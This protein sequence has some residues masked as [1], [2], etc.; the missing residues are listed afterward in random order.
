MKELLS[1]RKPVGHTEAVNSGGEDRVGEQTP[2]GRD[3]V[4][5]ALGNAIQG[6][7]RGRGHALRR[8]SR[9][10]SRSEGPQLVPVKVT[11]AQ[12]A[13]HYGWP[14]PADAGSRESRS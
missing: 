7:R 2:E 3:L 9:Q 1:G 13:D 14:M 11:V 5:I 6:A 8:R 10:W 4:R 12:V